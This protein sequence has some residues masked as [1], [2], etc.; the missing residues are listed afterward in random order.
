MEDVI[1]YHPEMPWHNA[2]PRGR[3]V[4][5]QT[6]SADDTQMPRSRLSRRMPRSASPCVPLKI[7]STPCA[8]SPVRVTLLCVCVCVTVCCV[9][10]EMCDACSRCMP[11]GDVCR[12]CCFLEDEAYS[13][14]RAYATLMFACFHGH[15]A[16]V[17][18]F[19]DAGANADALENP[20]WTALKLVCT[21]GHEACARVLVARGASVDAVTAGWTA[22]ASACY[23]GHEAC[24]R[25]LVEGGALVDMA[26]TGG[27]ALMAACFRGQVG[28][29]G[30][31][32]RVGAAV[33]ARDSGGRTALMIACARG[34]EAC[35]RILIEHGASV[36]ARSN[37][38][39]TVLIHAC[40]D[41]RGAACAR[42][43]LTAGASPDAARVADVGNTYSSTALSIACSGA[44][45]E[46]AQTLLEFGARLDPCTMTVVLREVRER[47]TSR[48]HDTVHL[49]NVATATY[50]YDALVRLF[51][52]GLSPTRARFCVVDPIVARVLGKRARDL[53][54]GVR[55]RLFSGAL[56]LPAPPLPAPHAVPV[57][58]LES[59]SAPVPVLLAPPAVPVLPL[60]SRD[61][62]QRRRRAAAFRAA[63]PALLA[64]VCH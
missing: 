3:H 53:D 11:C 48:A 34:H 12:A 7:T 24:A 17:S 38:G 45:C 62:P 20:N 23:A 5:I 21:I 8:L 30:L 42:I 50:A 56:S 14:T 61:A 59:R 29:M 40:G 27:T 35:A 44:L 6:M 33:D 15:A 39:L 58:P 55:E 28:C 36:N 54:G 18:T 49:L 16:C 2:V 52:G 41:S 22:L 47:S 63:C 31:M 19:L 1:A 64:R 60:E 43:L 13:F 32:L 37:D 46:C 26:G 10:G 9:C 51:L 25:V 4:N 57:L